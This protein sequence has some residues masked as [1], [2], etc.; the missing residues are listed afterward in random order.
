MNDYD[1][2][3]HD[4]NIGG[5][6]DGGENIHE[7]IAR[8]L[9]GEGCSIDDEVYSRNKK[10]VDKEDLKR[11]ENSDNRNWFIRLFRYL[12]EKFCGG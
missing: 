4:I 9:S 8:S 12:M 11:K 2:Y 5:E 7:E 10:V 1:D 3:G 6:I